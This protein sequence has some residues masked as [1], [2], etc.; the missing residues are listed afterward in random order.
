MAFI[1]LDTRNPIAETDVQSSEEHDGL[2]AGSA[3]E[4]SLL[5]FLGSG[6]PERDDCLSSLPQNRGGHPL[7]SF[8]HACYSEVVVV[9]LGGKRWGGRGPR[10]IHGADL[11]AGGAIG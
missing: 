6:V 10:K 11:A 9:L 2:R 3:R 5:S 4:W 7:R 8:R 1:R